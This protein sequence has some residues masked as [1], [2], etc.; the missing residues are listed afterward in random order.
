MIDKKNNIYKIFLQEVTL[1]DG[2][3]S[4]KEIEFEFENHDNIFD[5]IDKIQEKNIF[6]DKSHDIQFSLGLK[7]FSEVILQNR[8]NPLF[9]ELK[10]A[11]GQFMKKLKTFNSE[12]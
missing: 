9:E 11:I 3:Q 4:G 6:G 12:N 10:P 1:K 8:D 7:L 2:T 5:I